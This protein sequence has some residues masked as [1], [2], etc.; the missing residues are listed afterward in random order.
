MTQIQNWKALFSSSPLQL[1]V[2]LN[3]QNPFLSYYI[4]L[5]VAVLM[6][7]SCQDIAGFPSAHV[8]CRLLVLVCFRARTGAPKCTATLEPE[9]NKTQIELTERY[10]VLSNAVSPRNNF[11][12]LFLHK[13]LLSQ[14][15]FYMIVMQNEEIVCIQG[16]G[17]QRNTLLQTT[18]NLNAE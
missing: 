9:G 3:T 8:L 4:L 17:C 12:Q 5:P 7:L 18:L 15:L 16:F 6:L 10:Q 1:P 13:I 11:S 14:Y 2:C